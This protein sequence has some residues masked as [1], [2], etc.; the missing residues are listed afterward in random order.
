MHFGYV[1]IAAPLA[2]SLLF[3]GNRGLTNGQ[4]IQAI[5]AHA[6]QGVGNNES[7]AQAGSDTAP[8]KAHSDQ[9]GQ[10][11]DRLVGPTQDEARD[12]AARQPTVEELVVEI[13][14]NSSAT[15]LKVFKGESGLRAD[16]KGW[17]CY[18]GDVSKACAK[19]DRHKAWSVDCGVAQINVR[20]QE[21]PDDL[22]DARKNLE[23]AKSMFDRR[24]WC[25][26]YVAKKM[27]Y[28]SK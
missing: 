23:R 15:A 18:Y 16:A 4:G 26:W 1:L 25:P 17:N 24:G 12:Y 8:N 6:E 9:E 22:M 27:G 21:C 19:Q 14:G 20:G 2:I 13:F 10:S 28:C 5:E 11:S 3:G 7:E